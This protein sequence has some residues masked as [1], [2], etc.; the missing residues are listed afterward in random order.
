MASQSSKMSEG[1]QLNS[2]RRKPGISC[3]KL[4][5]ISL[6]NAYLEVLLSVEPNALFPLFQALAHLGT[7][8]ISP[9]QQVCHSAES[10]DTQRFSIAGTV[11]CSIQTGHQDRDFFLMPL[12][13]VLRSGQDTLPFLTGGNNNQFGVD[14]FQ[15]GLPRRGY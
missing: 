7:F 6:L 2:F 3:R 12:P 15:E 13:Q 1:E 9:V 5:W 14:L 4:S 11:D 8:P 10:I